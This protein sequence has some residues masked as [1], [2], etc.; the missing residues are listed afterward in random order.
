MMSVKYIYIFVIIF[1]LHSIVYSQN[2][3]NEL[4]KDPTYNQLDD[5]LNPLSQAFGSSLSSGIYYS[6]EAHNFPHFDLGI[7]YASTAIP[8]SKRIQD[9]SLHS[10]TVF[11]KALDDSTRLSGLNI[12]E[13]KI[14]VIHFSMGIGDNTEMIL[15]YTSWDIARIGKV[16]LL[17]GGIK[18]ELEN[19]LSIS[20]IP[21]DVAILAI[22]QKYEVDDILEGAVFNMNIV[23]SR[24]FGIIP[25]NIYGGIGYMNNTTNYNKNNGNE[26][27]SYSIG[28]LEEIKYQIGVSY[29]LLFFRLNVE[30]NFGKYNTFNGGIRLVL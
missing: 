7:T 21:V 22:Y 3:S 2:L 1:S 12:S 13:F 10:P 5:Y 19:L 18:Y 17:G 15:R 27:E 29:K 11:G 30:Y 26:E 14:P 23:A 4:L 20:P 9:D 25:L 24:H 8:S 28:G 16:K 6:A